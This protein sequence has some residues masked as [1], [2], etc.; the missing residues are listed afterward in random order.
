[1]EKNLRLTKIVATIGPASSDPKVIRDLIKAGTNVFRI[2]CSHSDFKTREYVIKTIRKCSRNLKKTIGILLDLQGPKIRVGKLNDSAVILKDGKNVILTSKEVLGTEEKIHIVSFNELV[3]SIKPSHRVLLDDGL[4][5]LLVLKKLG[6]KSVKC[7]IVYGGLLKDG[8]GVNCPDS[9]LKHIASLTK[10]DIQDLKHGLN[11]GVDLIALSF[12]RSASDILALKK[13]LPKKSVIKVIAKIE[14]P[15]AINDIKNILSVSD[16]IM[17]ARGDLG[18]ELPPEK[19]PSIQKQLIQKANENNV[20]VI[21]ATQMLES[22]IHSPKPTRAE[23]SDVANAIF[24]GTDAIMLSGETASG[25]YPALAVETMHKIALEAEAVAPRFRHAVKTNQENLARSACEL[26]ERVKA[27]AIA[28]FT[29]SGN[30]AKL[31]SK[32][33]PPVKVIALTQ[34]EVVSRQLSLCW[35]ITPLLLVE[36]HDTE[37]MM[38]LVEKTLF[39]HK[40]IKKGDIVIVTGGLPIAARGESNFVKIHRCE[41]KF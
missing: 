32:Q 23:V 7:K 37:T 4:I 33:R 20:L 29:L 10:K 40:L 24:D 34:N 1:M 8:K 13:L 18:V 15:Q 11:C 17:V 27:T 19:L 6:K 5:E 22:M 16:G 28:S 31:V 39:K 41:E 9:D 25:K 12:V 14:K 36:V 26:A 35:G 38:K 30:T 2:N 3:N 21:T